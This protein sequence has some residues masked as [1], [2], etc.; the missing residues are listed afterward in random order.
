[1]SFIQPI[2]CSSGGGE[3]ASCCPHIFTGYCLEDGTPIAITIVNGV[4]TTW[5]NLMTGVTTPGPPPVGSGIC[6][7]ESIEVEIRPLECD[8]DSI[9]VCPGDDPI[10]VEGTVTV[11]QGTSP[12]VIGDGGSSITVDAINLDIRDLVF[13]TDKLDVTGSFVTIDVANAATVSDPAQ[14]IT[15]AAAIV[16]VANPLRRSFT[17]QNTG[18]VPVYFTYGALSPTSTAYHF[19]LSPGVVADDGKGSFYADDQWS[20]DVQAFSSSPGSIVVM[21]IT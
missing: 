19:A 18:T 11:T 8:I 2:P 20:G 6:P 13:A 4:Q 21:E 9:T 12:W 1:V 3:S 5:T 7:A 16:L 15:G 17:L 14:T 10:V